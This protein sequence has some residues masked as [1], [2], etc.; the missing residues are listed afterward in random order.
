MIIQTRDDH[1]LDQG[2]LGWECESGQKWYVL[3]VQ[4]AGFAS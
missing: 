3:K 1:S 2:D 4:Q